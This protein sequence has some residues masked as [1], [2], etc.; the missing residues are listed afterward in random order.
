MILFS[1]RF[2]FAEYLFNNDFI[3]T[4]SFEVAPKVGYVWG[5]GNDSD[6]ESFV[7]ADLASTYTLP[8]GFSAEFNVYLTQHFFGKNA[9][10]VKENGT[11]DK[12]FDIA[13]EAYLYN[14]TNLYTNGNYALDFVFEGG[15]DPYTWSQEKVFDVD[16]KKYS[17]DMTYSLYAY[18]AVRLSY[19]AT[20]FINVY[21]LAGAEYRNY[22]VTEQSS[23][24]NWRWQ[25]TATVGFTTTF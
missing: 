17:D 2:D 5:D 24:Q 3:K 1:A 8:A 18:P 15:F 22:V 20:N 25:P 11:K 12:N 9:E 14:T 7:G 19:Q 23:A 21:A 10:L 16:T 4:D 6:Y 13:V